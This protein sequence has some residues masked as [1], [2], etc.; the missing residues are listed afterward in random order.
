MRIH[1][2]PQTFYTCSY[3]SLCVFSVNSI[4]LNEFKPTTHRKRFESVKL[5]NS[6]HRFSSVNRIYLFQPLLRNCLEHSINLLDH[7]SMDNVERFL[8]GINLFVNV[9]GVMKLNSYF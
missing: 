6:I 2:A 3:N 7:M 1:V 9:T 5:S 4:L 8:S